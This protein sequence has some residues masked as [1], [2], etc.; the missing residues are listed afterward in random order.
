MKNVFAAFLTFACL[1]FAQN[2]MAQTANA[3]KDEVKVAT[4]KISGLCCNGDLATLK[5]KLVNQ[6][7]VDEVTADNAKKEATNI[8]V[9]YHTGVISEEK[10]RSLIEKSAGCENPNETPY[11]VKAVTYL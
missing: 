4:I 11:K 9:K 2:G 3:P 7:G 1:F 6:E 5:K 8:K 10:I